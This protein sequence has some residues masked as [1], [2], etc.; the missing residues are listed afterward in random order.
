[1]QKAEII[2]YVSSVVILTLLMLVFYLINKADKR[3]EKIE[4]LRFSKLEDRIDKKDI[5][6]NAEKAVL[7]LVINGFTSQQIADQKFKAR[8]TVENQRR[9]IMDKLGCNSAI[10][11]IKILAN[12]DDE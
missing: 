5:L 7:K 4:D 8:G 12:E 10:E 11:A 3:K 2:L 9:S 1:M 6:S